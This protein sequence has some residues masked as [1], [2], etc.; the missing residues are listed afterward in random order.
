MTIL[1][2]VN[3]EPLVWQFLGVVFGIAFLGGLWRIV[4]EIGEGIAGGLAESRERKRIRSQRIE[5]AVSQ[6]GE[7]AAALEI[8]RQRRESK[9]EREHTK[10]QLLQGVVGDSK[11]EKVKFGLFI[12]FVV[13]AS[14]LAITR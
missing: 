2:L 9:A 10:N 12:A 11:S 8:E 6:G 14:L 1:S 5:R 4:A 13:I 7:E 3:R